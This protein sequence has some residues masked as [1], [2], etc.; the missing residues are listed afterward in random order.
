MQGDWGDRTRQEGPGA[1]P[2]VR[3][4]GLS[5]RGPWSR[6]VWKTDRKLATTSRAWA[7]TPSMAGVK[8][9]CHLLTVLKEHF[10]WLPREAVAGTL[11]GLACC[12]TAVLTMGLSDD[13]VGAQF[14]RR[15]L[16]DP[17]MDRNSPEPGQHT[18]LY[19]V[20]DPAD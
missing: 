11:W 4:R 18:G 10:W 7:F 15:P 1:D 16:R 6:Q 13:L 14:W 20:K 2:G 12:P 9:F 8:G 17:G 5:G 3:G 19:S